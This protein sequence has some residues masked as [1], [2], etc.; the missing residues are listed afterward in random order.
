MALLFRAVQAGEHAHLAFAHD[1][2]AAEIDGLPLKAVCGA[3]WVPDFTA[4]AHDLCPAC[5]AATE[6]DE[7]EWALIE[8]LLARGYSIDD[9]RAFG[10]TA[11]MPTPE[12]LRAGHAIAQWNVRYG[13]T[14]DAVTAAHATVETVSGR[15]A[16][17]MAALRAAGGQLEAAARDALAVPEAGVDE[18]DRPYRDGLR[19]Y[20]EA[21][22]QLG[23]IDPAGPVDEELLEGATALL[24]RGR[25]ITANATR[26][27][28]ELLARIQRG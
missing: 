4:A 19:S 5:A 14:R 6:G 22:Q 15:P 23:A 21:A 12:D 11:P 20:L 13:S 8:G 9:L 18:Y 16:P 3:V 7:A 1:V 17:D 25:T 10:H 28:K 27:T 26:Y 2:D 24:I